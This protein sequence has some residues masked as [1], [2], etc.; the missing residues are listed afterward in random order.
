MDNYK[1]YLVGTTSLL[2]RDHK[3]T[4]SDIIVDLDLNQII[5]QNDNVKELLSL[6]SE[7]K[8]FMENIQKHVKININEE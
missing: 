4:K 5:Y 8:C 7:E 3:K 6:N 1:S 2:I